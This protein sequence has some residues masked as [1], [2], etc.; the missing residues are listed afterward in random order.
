M[1]RQDKLYEAI[2]VGDRS[3]TEAAAHDALATG[4]DP[5]LLLNETMIPAMYELGSRFSR[6]ELGVPDLLVGARAMQ[7]GLAI[8]EPSMTTPHSRSRPRVCIGTVRGEHHTIGKNIVALVLR[9]A[10]YDVQDLGDDCTIEQYEEA[11]RG[12]CRAVL[13]SALMTNGMKNLRELVYHF[14]GRPELIVLVGGAAVTADFARSS[15]A[16]YGADAFEA[17]RLLDT[18][19]PSVNDKA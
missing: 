8:L 2:L 6:K 15:G 10:G 4:A 16:T 3:A 18:L 7:A 19:M 14:A 12:G 17:V 11:V 9:A 13:C 5:K 1:P